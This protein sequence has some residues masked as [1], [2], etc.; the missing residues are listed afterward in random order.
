MFRNILKSGGLPLVAALIALFGLAG[1]VHAQNRLNV[2]FM[3][4]SNPQWS[5][6]SLGT[7]PGATIGG[8]GC[9]VTAMAMALGSKG[10]NV[11]PAMLNAWL[12]RW[13]GYDSWCNIVWWRAAD[14]DGPA[15]LIWIGTGTL[16]NTPAGLK[17]MIDRGERIVAK[18]IRS[19]SHWVIIVGYLGNG[20]QWSHFMYYDPGDLQLTGRAVGDGLVKPG[21]PIRRYR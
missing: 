8:S 4:Q 12:T 1:A 2:P 21:A 5:G 19:S 7:C 9:A 13:Q 16:P 14:Y 18:S 11:N 17:A 15:G 3:S 10:A 20:T 6:V